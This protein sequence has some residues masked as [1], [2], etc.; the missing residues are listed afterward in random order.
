VTLQAYLGIFHDDRRVVDAEEEAVARTMPPRIPLS[1]RE[2]QDLQRVTL[3][4]LEVKGADPA[5]VRIPV[6]QPPRRPRSVFHA[7]LAQPGVSAIHVAHDDRDVLEPAIVASR[8]RRDRSTSWRQILR[9]LDLF[10]PESHP[11][12]AQPEPEHS[13]E[14]FV[15]LSPDLHVRG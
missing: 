15:V 5:R 7:M 4:I 3:G 13:L 1:R 14:A 10:V 12:D 6:R 2:P 8:V 9:Q 11:D